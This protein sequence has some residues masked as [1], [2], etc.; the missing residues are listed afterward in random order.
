MN[1]TIKMGLQEY[2]YNGG[3]NALVEFINNLTPVTSKYDA[4]HNKKYKLEK[5]IPFDLSIIP[6]GDIEAI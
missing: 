6:D 1:I 2:I 5:Q 3:I 4:D